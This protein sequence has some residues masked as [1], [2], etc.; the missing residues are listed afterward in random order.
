MGGFAERKGGLSVLE[1]V[2]CCAIVVVAF[3][4]VAPMF[5][6]ARK[7][8]HGAAPCPTSMAQIGRALKMYFSEWHD[9]YPT[10]R[11]YLPNGR[12]G[13]IASH[14][15]LTPGGQTSPD[16]TP[17]RFQYGVSWV[18][19]LY[20]YVEAVSKD[21]A[22]A[23]SCEMASNGRYPENSKTAAVSYVMNR[24]LIERPE[25]CIRCASNLMMYREMDRRVDSDLRPTN[26]SC[27]LPDAPP[28]SPFLTTHDSRIGN[29]SAKLHN[30]GSNVMFA[31]SHVKRYPTE[32][33]TQ[34]M[35]RSR[36]WDPN[37]QWYNSADASNSKTYKAIAI[38]P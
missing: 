5:V 10:N 7:T 33:F 29:T 21:S 9:V 32:F 3:L 17:R 1:A 22:G 30:A 4:F 18:E 14:V 37:G 16:G 26:Y 36:C 15:K 24:N 19:A 11:V 23:W 6:R 25:R 20:P 31:D 38:T 27:G 8:D 28:D 34:R 2:A 35:T 12:V 13:R